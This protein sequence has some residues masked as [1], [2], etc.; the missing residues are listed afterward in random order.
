METE[1]QAS[2]ED[3]LWFINVHL[4][5]SGK[6]AFHEA[7][8]EIIFNR[9]MMMNVSDETLVAN[10]P[11]V[12][13]VKIEMERLEKERQPANDPFRNAFPPQPP[14]KGRVMKAAVMVNEKRRILATQIY[15][16]RGRANPERGAGIG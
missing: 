15:H 13:D 2:F 4:A 10:H 11:W 1:Y 9:D 12:T 3:L 7:D 16:F 14:H 8:L 5:N 6:G